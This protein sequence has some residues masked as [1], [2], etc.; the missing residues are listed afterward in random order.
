[1]G[2]IIL[3]I[4]TAI[5]ILSLVKKLV[6]FAVFVA[7]IYFVCVCVYFLGFHPQSLLHF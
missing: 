7:A 1:M 6:K 2:Y 3:A 5:V 4:I